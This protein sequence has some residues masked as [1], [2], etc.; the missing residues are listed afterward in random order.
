M[1]WAERSSFSTLGPGWR[2]LPVGM[3]LGGG[4]VAL[5][6]ASSRLMRTVLMEGSFA[7]STVTGDFLPLT[8]KTSER[9]SL[10]AVSRSS[11]EVG[12]VLPARGNMFC[13]WSKKGRHACRPL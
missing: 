12:K 5:T 1:G 9:A 13:P 7:P 2:D 3:G 11:G 4:L 10:I 6:V 8:E